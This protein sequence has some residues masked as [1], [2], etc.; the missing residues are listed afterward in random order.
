MAC[1]TQEKGAARA[2]GR[3]RPPPGR[4]STAWRAFERHYVLV[5]WAIHTAVVCGLAAGEVAATASAARRGVAAPPWRLV[6]LP[7][8]VPFLVLA[9]MAATLVFWKIRLVQ[10]GVVSSYEETLIFRPFRALLTNSGL[11]K[12]F[13]LDDINTC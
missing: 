11:A 4:M 2:A 3:V 6:T 8:T 12:L 13:G 10:G 1:S 9:Q 7:Y 5:W